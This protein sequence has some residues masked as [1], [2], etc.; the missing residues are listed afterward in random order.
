MDPQVFFVAVVKRLGILSSVQRR[1]F[2][3]SVPKEND[4]NF[5]S[6]F[7]LFLTWFFL[8]VLGIDLNSFGL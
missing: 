5:E 1:T 2:I 3:K 7:F 8:T 6:F 4:M